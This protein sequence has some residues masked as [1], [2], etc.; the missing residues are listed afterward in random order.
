[1]TING[2]DREL[3]TVFATSCFWQG[4]LADAAGEDGGPTSP[5]HLKE[6][7]TPLPVEEIDE[8]VSD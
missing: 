5:D 1:M 8:C 4:D 3:T 6:I 2:T 7:S